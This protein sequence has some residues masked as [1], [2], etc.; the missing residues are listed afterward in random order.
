[1]ILYG[2]SGHGK[3]ILDILESIHEPAIEIWDDADK[4]PI[5]EYSVL[6]PKAT[7]ADKIV[8]GIG[9]NETRKKIAERLT[10]AVTISRRGRQ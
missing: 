7:V 6:K 10:G 4:A 1:M 2:A 5:W 9:I 3:V 8:I